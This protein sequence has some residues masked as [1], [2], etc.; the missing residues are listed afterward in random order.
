MLS[1][2]EKLKLEAAVA[3]AKGH[4]ANYEVAIAERE[5]DIERIAVQIEMQKKLVEQAEARLSGQV[6]DG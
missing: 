6:V 4:V 5:A 3:T 1:K 2:V